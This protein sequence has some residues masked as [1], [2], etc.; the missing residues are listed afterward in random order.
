MRAGFGYGRDGLTLD[1]PDGAEVFESRFPEPSGPADDLVLHAVRHPVESP[2]LGEALA[3]RRSGDVVVVVSDA[4][5]PVPYAEFLPGLLGEIEAA[6]VL[7]E[8]ILILVAT[9]THRASTPE[10]RVE[11][12]GRSVAENYLIVDHSADDDA[13]LVELPG[14]SASGARVRLNRH[15]MAA[16]F[17]LV[18]GLVEPHF[19]A[20]FSGGRKAVCP[21][22]ADL[23]TVRQFHGPEFLA[24]P[25][26]T[27]GRLEGNPLHEEARSV[28]RLAGVDFSLNVVIDRSRRVVGAFAGALEAAHEAACR[29]AADCTCRK[30]ERPADVV[31][32]SCGGHPLD[33]TFYQC[34]KGMVSCLPAVRSGGAVIAFGAC[35]EGIGSPEYGALMRR[36]AGRWR[37]FL[38]DI[39][40][41]GVFTRDQWEFQMQCRALEKVE[42]GGLHFVTGGLSSEELAV[43]SV[44]PHRVEDG[45]V[46]A[47]VQG[48]V[49]AHA[50]GGTVAVFPEGP[51][52]AAV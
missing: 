9:G 47:A 35:S 23:A 8:E 1:V 4:T 41:P 43:L 36:Y 16:G 3:K 42:Q 34:V 13:G 44:T 19:M 22:L 28:A 29:L 2:P 46:A 45:D 24:D 25:R 21:G 15:F 37:A 12:F 20:G 14:R 30:A 5:R 38:E 7:Q 39:G 51:Y 33:A 32:T 50:A 40:K 10:E 17:R 26:A 48:L 18:T 52:C 31:V 49:D 11:M 6:G 27:N